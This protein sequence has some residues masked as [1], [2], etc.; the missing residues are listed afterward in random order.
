MLVARL[1]QLKGNKTQSTNFS[2]SLQPAI[3]LRLA[4]PSLVTKD[5]VGTI[6]VV[7]SSAH[8]Y[9]HLDMIPTLKEPSKAL[10]M[11]NIIPSNF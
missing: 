11:H 1:L 2:N 7:N 5:K 8:Y 6:Y 3:S 10:G 4:I 9:F